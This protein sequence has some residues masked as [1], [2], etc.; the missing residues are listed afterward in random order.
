MSK[1]SRLNYKFQPNCVKLSHEKLQW[2][3][4][5]NMYISV[6][7]WG[8]HELLWEIK[9]NLKQ[10]WFGQFILV[11]RGLKARLIHPQVQLYAMWNKFFAQLDFLDGFE[12]TPD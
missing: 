2:R 12:L 11:W 5:N 3:F 6:G 1:L 9:Y 7:N 10:D 4:Q 8:F